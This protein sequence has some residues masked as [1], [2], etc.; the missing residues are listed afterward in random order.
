MLFQGLMIVIAVTG[1]VACGKSSF[2]EQFRSE[3]GKS[4]SYFSC[5]AEVAELLGGAEIQTAICSLDGAGEV[6]VRDGYDKEVV[7]QQAFDEPGFR[8][9]LE[10]LLHPIILERS[11]DFLNNLSNEVRLALV[12]VPLLYEADFRVPRDLELVVAASR[13]TQVDRLV[14]QR[15]LAPEMAEKIIE[16]QYPLDKKVEHSDIVVWNDGES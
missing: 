2:C 13:S 5:D 11:I 4:V 12:E 7:R 1:G 15:G 10:N 3:G 14:R 9:N 6:L 16:A 8:E